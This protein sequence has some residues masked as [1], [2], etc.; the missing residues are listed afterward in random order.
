MTAHHETPAGRAGPLEVTISR[1]KA[2]K[3][4]AV[5]AALLLFSVLTVVF[6]PSAGGL[7]EVV[8]IVSMVSIGLSLLKG[9]PRLLRK[10][11]VVLRLDAEGV[12]ARHAPALRWKELS[13]IRIAQLRPQFLFSSRR[14]A[15]RVM[16][17]IP[18]DVAA[19]LHGWPS[20]KRFRARPAVRLYGSPVMVLEATLSL[21]M[22]ELKTET[23][24]RSGLTV[25]YAP[26]TA[27]RT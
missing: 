2:A 22:E 14:E 10:R 26:G 5:G 17:F 4:M 18:F 25:E 16:I 13:T 6:D 24:T 27:R 15:M 11:T 19:Y 20:W 1:R 3:N 8:L 21:T 23:E 12:T 7:L 9:A